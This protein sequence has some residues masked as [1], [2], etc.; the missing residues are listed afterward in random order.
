MKVI[1]L[2]KN[3]LSGPQ[4]V[5]KLR[6]IDVLIGQGKSEPRDRT[7]SLLTMMMLTTVVL[8]T[9]SAIAQ[10]R[11]IY[12]AND[13]HTDYLWTADEQTYER[14][15]QEMID[16]YL[17]LADATDA[18]PATCQSRFNCDG[19][20]WLWV[21]EKHRTPEEFQRL[22]TRLRSGH[23]SAPMTTLVSCYGGQPAEA[24]LRGMYYAGRLE[25]RHDLRFSLAVAMENQ[26]L[27][28]GLASLW[29]GAGARYSWRGVCAC[30]S[31][32]P[33]KVLHRRP[34]EIYWYTGHDGQRVLMKW[35]SLASSGNK[36]IG[37]YA[38]AF[39]PVAAVKFLDTDTEFLRR[40]RSP[41][42]TQPYAVRGAFG[43]GWD[44]LDRKTGQPYLANEKAYPV[45]DH[46][47][48]VAR[49]HST[50]ERQVIVSNEED[51]FRD[52]EALYGT[53]LPTESVTYGN[54]WELYSAS[55]AETS[56]CV[57]RSVEKLRP[58]E[59]MATLVSLKEPAFL[60]GREAARDLAFIDLGLYW[61]HDWTADGRVPRALRAAW[62]ERLAGEIQVYV[63]TLHTDAAQRLGMLIQ[64][65]EATAQRFY[66]LN[67]LGWTRTDYADFAYSGSKNIHVQDVSI[68]SDVPHQ[69]VRLGGAT[70]LRV[71]ASDVPSAGYKAFEILSGPGSAPTDAAAT[72]GVNNTTLENTHVKSPA[73]YPRPS[74][75]LN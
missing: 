4:I 29:S 73:W 32:V 8:L 70:F 10:S 75:M 2:M 50:A 7:Y 59:L 66:V 19:N 12:L 6:Q 34:Y 51:F 5:A 41:G 64:Q 26:T 54:E 3:R 52:F 72:V 33:S 24:V 63:D 16:Y 58:A 20:Y 57:R 28:L 39:D 22:I 69:F 48:N 61:E 43:F 71:L 68:V 23:F 46:F 30:A 36:S 53:Q 9:T 13:G 74:P 35:H 31:K 60:R 17:D 62:Q 25:R 44:A 37:G 27:P 42:A 1:V 45:T 15:F 56:A 49:E 67:P 40:Y 38:E 11:R 21:Y 14:V 65:P 18:N 47:H 55:M